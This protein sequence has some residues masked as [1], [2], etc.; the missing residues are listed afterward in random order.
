MRAMRLRAVVVVASDKVYANP[1]T[2]QP[3]TEQD[4]LGGHDPYSA[5]KA[6]A[7]IVVA[8]YRS[9]FFGEGRHPA[10][11]ASAR[12]GNV[13]G[14]GDWAADRLVGRLDDLLQRVMVKDQVAIDPGYLAWAGIAVFKRA[15][16]LYQQ[17]KAKVMRAPAHA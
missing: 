11:I 13:I 4:P 5:S 10:R 8:S 6:A 17:Y 1:E 15:H 9:S 14:G 3:F 7:E 16:A 2:G 12:A